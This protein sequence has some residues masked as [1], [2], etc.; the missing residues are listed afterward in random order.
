MTFDPLSLRRASF[1]G[2][3]FWVLHGDAEAGHRVS[4]TGIPGGR[5]INESFGPAARKFEIEAYCVGA[6]AYA[7]DALLLASENMHLGVL[8]LPD[9]LAATV[10]L[11]KARR[12]FERDKLGYIVVSLEA[13]G[14]P[15]PA[16]SGLSA[17]AF[18]QRIYTLAQEAVPLFG[19][20]ASGFVTSLPAAREA[21]QDAG[22]SV[23]A[24]LSAVATL[25]RLAPASAAKVD[26]AIAAAFSALNAVQSD[27]VPFGEA[28]ANAAIVLGDEA[29]PSQLGESLRLLG[30]PQ[31]AAEASTAS[32]VAQAIAAIDANATR[33][34]GALR[35]LA[36]GESQARAEWADRPAAEASRALAAAVFEDALSRL[37][38]ESLGLH[39]TLAQLRGVVTERA[40]ARAASLAPLVLVSTPNRMPSLVWS[41]RLYG[42]AQ[43]SAELV[44]RS[45][46]S[47]PGFLPE[48]FEALA[49]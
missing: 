23:V 31:A 17:F 30:A 25:G 42:T 3:P 39:R 36:L 33:M 43:R 46:A 35:A 22:A 32:Q 19:S 7:A 44:A 2:I 8:I 40:T 47:H 26:A 18:D 27:P 28:L 16:T 5:H 15:A 41:W 34:I 11:T 24:D 9:Q 48:R 45:R 12:R 1:N 37:G 21:A 10:R 38:R 13:V 6:N 4:T 14:E 29:D 20:L 49:S